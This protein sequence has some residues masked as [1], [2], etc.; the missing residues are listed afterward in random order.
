MMPNKWDVW[1]VNMPYEEGIG[2]KVR[3]ALV[4]DPQHNYVIVGKMT[5]HAPRDNFPYEYAVQDWQGAGLTRPTTLRLSQRPRLNA[6][7]FIKK[8]G[9]M[10]PK[11]LVE[12]YSILN[13]IANE[14]SH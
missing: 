6:T 3:P 4:I 14:E 7:C 13:D 1:L 8:L 2:S 11:D 10:Q 9:V 5:S 12:I